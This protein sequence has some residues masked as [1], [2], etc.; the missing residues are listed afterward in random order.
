ME[1]VPLVEDNAVAAIIGDL[2]SFDKP[3]DS[4]FELVY[5]FQTKA[6]VCYGCSKK[7]ER[8]DDQNKMVIRKYC[9][10]EFKHGG[11]LKKK[12]QFAYFHLKKLCVTNKFPDFALKDLVAAAECKQIIPVNLKEKLSS[13][14]V[15]L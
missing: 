1:R 5:L 2:E 13:Y 9:E 3:E 6:T 12:W 4:N 7:F 15:K 8:D 14:G 11:E 10:R